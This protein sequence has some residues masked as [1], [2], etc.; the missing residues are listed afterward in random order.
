MPGRRS[1]APTEAFSTWPENIFFGLARDEGPPPLLCA[2]QV[3]I[4]YLIQTFS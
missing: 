2:I 3:E 1:D 4:V